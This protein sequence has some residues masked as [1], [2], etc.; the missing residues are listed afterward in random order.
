MITQFSNFETY[1][2][3]QLRFINN[4]VNFCFVLT[5]VISR[6][7]F[8]FLYQQLILQTAARTSTKHKYIETLD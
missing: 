6:G 7:Y 5:N 2:K 1:S 4:N 3:N 8:K